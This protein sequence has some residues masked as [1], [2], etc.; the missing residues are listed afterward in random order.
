MKNLLK[1]T[2]VLMSYLILILFSINATVAYA[3]ENAPKKYMDYSTLDNIITVVQYKDTGLAFSYDDYNYSPSSTYS[4]YHLKNNN[5]KKI[6]GNAN[7]AYFYAINRNDNI[8]YFKN[9]DPRYVVD[10]ELYHN[11]D[12]T[13]TTAFYTHADEIEKNN[14]IKKVVTKKVNKEFNSNYN[15]NNIES[16]S[17]EEKYDLKGTKYTTFIMRPQENNPN[18]FFTGVYNDNFQYLSTNTISVDFDNKNRPFITE[19]N[20][21]SVSLIIVDNKNLLRFSI[22]ENIQSNIYVVDNHFYF[23]G[24]DFTLNSYSFN[25]NKFSLDKKYTGSIKQLT[26]DKDGN[27]WALKNADGRKIVSKLENNELMEKYEVNKDMT[28]LSVYD[29]NNMTVYTIDKFTTINNT[30]DNNCND[31]NDTNDTKNNTNNND[32][33]NIK[34][35][36]QTGSPINTKTLL[37]LASLLTTLGGTVFIKKRL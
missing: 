19:Y 24:E 7:H 27:L 1:L 4:L 20:G 2:S 5:A 12:T 23:L 13:Y 21:E 17:F 9:N 15:S 22:N 31:T 14:S 35:L 10:S 16:F 32:K 36:T 11:F 18:N 29:D 6:F 26:T 28:N 30:E 8:V 37:I 3:Q 25:G 33:N 34:R